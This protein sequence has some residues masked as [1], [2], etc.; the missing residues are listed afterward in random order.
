M[1]YQTSSNNTISNNTIE[2]T[3]DE[4]PKQQSRPRFSHRGKYVHAYE[5]AD[6]H[7]YKQRIGCDYLMKY[8]RQKLPAKKPLHV[9]VRF[10]R[11]IQKSLSHKEYVRRKKNVVMPIIKPDLDNYIKSVLDGLNGLAFEDDNQIIRIDAIKLYSDHP[12]TEILI[13]IM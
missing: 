7:R 12:R 8:G 4:E 1:I 5:K 2:L 9:I 6:I 13:G 3:I 11:P 10:Y